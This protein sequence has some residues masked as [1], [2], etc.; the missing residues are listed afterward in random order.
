MNIS[1]LG[2][3]CYKWVK[4]I[5]ACTK[6]YKFFGVLIAGFL[7]GTFLEWPFVEILFLLISVWA[8][9]KEVPSHYFIVPTFFLFGVIPILLSMK[10]PEQA[11]E[12]SVYAYY[13]IVIAVV[14]AVLE[15]RKAKKNNKVD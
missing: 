8:I 14:L 15:I 5:L 7:V 2:L 1:T 9:M 10:R 6:E 3:I 12:F 13:L 11:E 4:W